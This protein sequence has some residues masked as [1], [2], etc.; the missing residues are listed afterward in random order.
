[1]KEPLS[2]KRLEKLETNAGDKYTIKIRLVRFA[3]GY[4][5]SMQFIAHIH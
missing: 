3:Q 2:A 4:D 5:L 1:M